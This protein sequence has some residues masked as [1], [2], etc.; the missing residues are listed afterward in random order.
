M[1][2]VKTLSPKTMS[3]WGL[4]KLI[5]ILNPSS[6]V[7]QNTRS[8][9]ANCLASPWLHSLPPPLPL[10]FFTAASPCYALSWRICCTPIQQES[11]WITTMPD[12]V[13]G[14]RAVTV[15]RSR[16]VVSGSYADLRRFPRRGF[17]RLGE[18]AQAL[19]HELT[20]RLPD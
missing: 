17:E 13:G 14:F 10:L 3:T 16:S 4:A 2:E 15:G 7:G 6:A 18:L 19:V 9:R 1:P 20:Q 11:S 12:Q 8:Q 5:N